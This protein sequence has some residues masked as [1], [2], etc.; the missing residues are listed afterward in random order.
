MNDINN[1]GVRGQILYTPSD[2]VQITLIGDVSNQKPTGYGWP[3]A[4]VVTT[5]R[6]AYRQF[7]AII[8]DLNIQASLY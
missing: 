1:I 4:G 3:V 7:N 8:A 5:Q 6:A 2:N